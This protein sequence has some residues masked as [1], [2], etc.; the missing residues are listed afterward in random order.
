MR[1]GSCCLEKLR[2]V[3]VV[4]EEVGIGWLFA[5]LPQ[6][7][8]YLAAMQR[9]VVHRV[10]QDLPA[11]DGA[12]DSSEFSVYLGFRHRLDVFVESIRDCRPCLFQLVKAWFGVGVA[13][14]LL[15]A[16]FDAWWE[17]V[18]LEAF[19]PDALGVE[20]VAQGLQDAGVGCLQVAV[21]FF[22]R[23]R[24]A[25]GEQEVVGPGGVVNLREQDLAG[26]WHGGS[27]SLEAKA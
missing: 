11:K 24:G 1:N 27:I 21:Q 6:H 8:G 5:E 9:G 20:G 23:D 13:E 14:E 22:W 3:E 19:E 17:C 15:I 25:G 16:N 2:V 4:G 12:V 10:E 18:G 26:D 7:A